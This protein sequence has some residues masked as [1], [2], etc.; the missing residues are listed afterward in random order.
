MKTVKIF[1]EGIREVHPQVFRNDPSVGGMAMEQILDLGLYNLAKAFVNMYEEKGRE[2][3][4]LWFVSK[5]DA[6]KQL[7]VAPYVKVAFEKSGYSFN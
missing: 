1:E 4:L 3:A 2:A 7:A 6:E 5:V